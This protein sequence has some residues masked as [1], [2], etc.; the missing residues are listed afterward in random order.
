MCLLSAVLVVGSAY[1]LCLLTAWWKKYKLIPS[2]KWFILWDIL[3]STWVLWFWSPIYQAVGHCV[4]LAPVACRCLL[5]DSPLLVA[6]PS[7]L[8]V[9]ESGMLCHRRRHQP[10]RCLCSVSVWSR[11]SSDDPIQTST[12]DVFTVRLLL[13]TTV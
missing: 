3:V 1:I 12:S 10:S 4:L 2:L 13:L 11:T 9:H 8:P 6:G 7:R 5:T